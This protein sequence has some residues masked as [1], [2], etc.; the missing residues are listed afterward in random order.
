MD[1]EVLLK[2]IEYFPDYF[3]ALSCMLLGFSWTTF[4][5][6][7]VYTDEH[8]EVDIDG[9]TTEFARLKARRLAPFACEP[10]D[11]VTVLPFFCFS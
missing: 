9:V 1:S 4:V 7:A 5:E 6:T 11:G 2:F 10:L 3:S 8:K